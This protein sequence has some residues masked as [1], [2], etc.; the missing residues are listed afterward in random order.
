MQSCFT[1][2]NLYFEKY[3]FY[4]FITKEHS[5]KPSFNI[6]HGFK[7]LPNPPKSCGVTLLPRA[8]DMPNPY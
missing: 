3:T 6:N 1:K 8:S 2:I 5:N 7:R 4:S